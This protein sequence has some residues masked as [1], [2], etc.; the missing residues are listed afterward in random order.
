MRRQA[1]LVTNPYENFRTFRKKKTTVVLPGEEPPAKPIATITNSVPKSNLVNT[2]AATGVVHTT[3]ATT[4]AISATNTVTTA[5][6]TVMSTATQSTAPKVSANSNSI[7][8]C[9]SVPQDPS[10]PMF[11]DV[12]RGSLSS[13]K[14]SPGQTKVGF[15]VSISVDIR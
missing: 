14:F 15:L 4:V 11:N 5:A 3:T 2:S 6:Q 12:R 13:S 10:K 8:S 7:T 1:F 9:T